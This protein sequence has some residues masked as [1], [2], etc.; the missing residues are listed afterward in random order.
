MEMVMI[1][2]QRICINLPSH[3]IMSDFTIKDTEFSG[4]KTLGKFPMDI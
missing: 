1:K 3:S 2:I 4:P